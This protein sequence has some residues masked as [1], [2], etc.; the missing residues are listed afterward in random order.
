MAA[1]GAAVRDPKTFVPEEPSASALATPLVLLAALLVSFT[2]VALF[3][4]HNH[5]W[6]DSLM[7][8]LPLP[9]AEA[10]LA[11]D[12]SLRSQLTLRDLRAWDATLADQTSLLL[13]EATVVNDA[14]V[15]VRRI[16]VTAEARVDGRVIATQTATCG[17]AVSSRLLRRMGRDELSALREIDPPVALEPGEH[18]PCQL[19]F[20]GIAPGIK[21]VTLRVASAEPLPGHREPAFAPPE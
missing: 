6:T 13:A 16:V 14:L 5:A 8:K 11:A 19:A 10:S 15:P 17:K 12:P 1:V 3:M 18:L 21:E 4:T 9:G 7:A 20:A 2:L